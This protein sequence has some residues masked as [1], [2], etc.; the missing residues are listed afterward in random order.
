MKSGG[1][2]GGGVVKQGREFNEVKR[3]RGE[4]VRE[5]DKCK[6]L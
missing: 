4:V 6:L 5:R 3:R 1:S 2:E